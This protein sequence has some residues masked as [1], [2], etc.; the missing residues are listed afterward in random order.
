MRP[1]DRPHPAPEKNLTILQVR[2]PVSLPSRY[3]PRRQANPPPFAQ[4]RK[5]DTD[6]ASLTS[7]VISH[8]ATRPPVR[9]KPDPVPLGDT[10]PDQVRVTIREVPCFH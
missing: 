2:H 1:S 6:H 9:P 4:P 10:L 5:T 8:Q 7:T 3:N